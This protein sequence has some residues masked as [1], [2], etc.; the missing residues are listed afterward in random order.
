MAPPLFHSIVYEI[1]EYLIY[2][3]EISIF[4][5][6]SEKVVAPYG[7]LSKYSKSNDMKKLKKMKL[8]KIE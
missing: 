3:N 8:K 7:K 4:V 1:I 2:L 6:M 5:K